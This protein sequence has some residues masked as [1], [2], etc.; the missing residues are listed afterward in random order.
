MT[1]KRVLFYSESSLLSTGYSNYT[2]EVLTR[3]HKTG[4]YEL[5]EIAS[6][7][8]GTDPRIDKLPWLHYPVKPRPE[9]T[10]KLK[11]FNS[12]A[13]YQFGE[14]V[15]DDVCLTFK[16]DIILSIRDEWMDSYIYSSPARKYFK[17][18]YMPPVDS[19]P[20]KAE[21]MFS[22]S[23]ADKLLTYTDWGA[24]VL[25]EQSNN[26][27]K[28]ERA[29]Y[30]GVDLNVFRPRNRN[31]IRA[32]V[33]LSPDMLIVG[34]VMRNQVRKLY[35]DLFQAFRKFLDTAHPLIAE[36][37]YLYVHACYPDVGWKFHDLI[38][39]HGI[40]HR[41][42][43]SYICADCHEVYC[44]FFRDGRSLCKHC[45][46]YNAFMPGI[47]TGVESSVLAQIYSL[48]DCYVQYATCEGFGMPVA[49]AASCGVPVFAV[50][51]SAMSDVVRKVDGFPIKVERLFRD[52]GVEA[53]RALPDNDDFIN[54]LEQ[55]LRQPKEIRVKYEDLARKGCVEYFDW[56]K[57]AKTWEETIDDTEVDPTTWDLPPNIHEMPTSVPGDLSEAEFVR[58]GMEHIAGRPDLKNSY[59]ATRLTRDLMLGTCLEGLPSA[60]A[61]PDLSAEATGRW[62]DLNRDVLV[63]LFV[64]LGDVKNAFERR[65]C[66]L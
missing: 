25:R 34:T 50:D 53:D 29:A 40:T 43:F 49:E 46:N 65:R 13:S 51:Y 37:A 11:A 20:Q 2:F 54:Q 48:F 33:G 66:K 56:D 10:E 22:F 27:L 41:V 5:A 47:K 7:S 30:A 32:K 55:Y 59:F 31:E 42:L 52:Q 8:D 60:L 15:L 61:N 16:P 44:S 3:L 12:K 14:W 39:E 57:V 6:Y 23:T 38:K 35:P 4:K 62:G 19:K 45:G 63:R 24:E 64:F 26:K 18:I 28:I 9:E 17:H 1:K 58:W 36:K 21:W